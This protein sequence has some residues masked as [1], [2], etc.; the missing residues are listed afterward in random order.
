LAFNTLNLNRD[1]VRNLS[2]NCVMQNIQ[3]QMQTI[4]MLL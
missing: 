1:L 2:L 4:I 3:H